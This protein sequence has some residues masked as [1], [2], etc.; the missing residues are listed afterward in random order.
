MLRPLVADGRGYDAKPTTEQELVAALQDMDTQFR[1]EGD[2]RLVVIFAYPE[3]PDTP[4]LSIG[5]GANESV[6]T[7]DESIETGEGAISLGPRVDDHSDVGFSYGT[8]YSGFLASHL[9]PKDDAIAAAREFFRTG[10]RPTNLD[11]EE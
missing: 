4:R 9:V 5:L 10:R 11:W 1:A 7:Y 2:P 8:G 3:V 6:V